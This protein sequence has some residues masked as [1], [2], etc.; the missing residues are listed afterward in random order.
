M[1][2]GKPL[3]LNYEKHNA[4]E[5]TRKRLPLLKGWN[6]VNDADP[7]LLLDRG[8]DKVVHVTRE[9]LDLLRSLVL[10]HRKVKN[11]KGYIKLALEEPDFFITKKNKYDL[12]NKEIDDP[13]FFRL[14]L[15][16]WNKHLSIIFNDLLDFLEFPK[17]NRIRLVPVKQ[18]KRNFEG[19][20]CS[21]LS[22]EHIPSENIQLIRE[23]G[24]FE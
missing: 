9:L 20:S 14:S 21:H 16:D 18:K 10:Y 22:K 12:L 15:E 7:Q 3:E 5:A 2:F 4:F 11:W 8:Y 1:Q 13:N 19:Y 24:G 17:K 6:S 23:E